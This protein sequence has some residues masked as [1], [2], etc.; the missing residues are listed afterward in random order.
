[1]KD[2]KG[3]EGRNSRKS[4]QEKVWVGRRSRM[5]RQERWKRKGMDKDRE[6][7][8]LGRQPMVENI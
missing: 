7:K 8:G 4:R 2:K 1:M 6:G 5:E 3:E